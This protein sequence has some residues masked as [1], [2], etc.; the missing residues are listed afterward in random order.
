M[1]AHMIKTTV[2]YTK[3]F[4]TQ[5]Q[6]ISFQDRSLGVSDIHGHAVWK[7]QLELVYLHSLK[8]QCHEILAFGFR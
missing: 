7:A 3:A 1:P 2:L 5:I 4:S 8:G 6:A